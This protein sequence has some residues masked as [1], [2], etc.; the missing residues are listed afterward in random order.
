MASSAA[1]RTPTGQREGLTV[2]DTL[3]PDIEAQRNALADRLFGSANATLDMAAV[4]LGDRLG[5][6]RALADGGP[7]TSS[8]L[9]VRTSLNER[10][11]REWLEQQAVTGI[12]VADASD[13]AGARRY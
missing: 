9:A 8:E 7:A 4:Y 3:D 2:V 6:F 1:C 10:Y 12:L 11:V 13:D 5:L